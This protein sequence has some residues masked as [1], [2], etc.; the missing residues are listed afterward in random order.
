METLVSCLMRLNG[1][2][3]LGDRSFGHTILMIFN[4]GVEYE[5]NAKVPKWNL[6]FQII[7]FYNI[8]N[9]LIV[10][11]ISLIWLDKVN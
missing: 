1:R 2:V 7:S 10:M 11:S 4:S 6:K 5:A 8:R 9:K 3:D